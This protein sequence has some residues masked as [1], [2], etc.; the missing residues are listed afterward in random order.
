MKAEK[1]KPLNAQVTEPATAE[2][3][4]PN[5]FVNFEQEM[6]T[7]FVYRHLLRNFP[8]EIEKKDAAREAGSIENKVR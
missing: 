4:Q 5:A 2:S 8:A 7:I 6:V 1:H 3:A